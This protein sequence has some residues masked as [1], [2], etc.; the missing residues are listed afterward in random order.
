MLSL[1]FNSVGNEMIFLSIPFDFLCL[2]RCQGRGHEVC[3]ENIIIPV[4]ETSLEPPDYSHRSNIGQH[5][6]SRFYRA[7]L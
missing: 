5:E 7:N 1:T 3:I 4:T 2:D 6:D